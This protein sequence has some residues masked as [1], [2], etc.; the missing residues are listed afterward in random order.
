MRFPKE[1]VGTRRAHQETLRLRCLAVRAACVANVKR[2]TVQRTGTQTSTVTDCSQS[3]TAQSKSLLLLYR[4]SSGPAAPTS[5]SASGRALSPAAAAADL[6][7]PREGHPPAL[8]L[9][10][11]S[12]SMHAQSFVIRSTNRRGASPAAPPF[13]R[14]AVFRSVRYVRVP[15]S[16]V[17]PRAS[18]HDDAEREDGAGAGARSSPPQGRAL[19]GAGATLRAALVHG[20]ADDHSSGVLPR[21]LGHVLLAGAAPRLLRVGTPFALYVIWN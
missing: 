16:I 2:R 1:A 17:P 20:G 19:G 12:V 10:T 9:H 15:T 21:R 5:A 11:A 18:Q 3:M 14:V 6:L 8:G 7:R 13:G 4:C